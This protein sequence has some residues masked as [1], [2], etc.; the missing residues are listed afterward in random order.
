[1]KKTK[2]KITLLLLPALA[3]TVFCFYLLLG[4]MP[5]AAVTPPPAPDKPLIADPHTPAAEQLRLRIPREP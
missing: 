4:G 3:A 1:M 5:V 2:L